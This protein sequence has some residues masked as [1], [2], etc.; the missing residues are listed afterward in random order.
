MPALTV[1]A[2][3]PSPRNAPQLWGCGRRS[4]SVRRCATW[5]PACRTSWRGEGPAAALLAIGIL[6]ALT[7]VLTLI[8][9]RVFRW[10]EI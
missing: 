7:V 1:L 9:A 10:D 8:S 3:G 4:A 2:R 6:T 5:P